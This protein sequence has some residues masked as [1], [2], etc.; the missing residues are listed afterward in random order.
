M[1]QHR[2]P[3]HQ[4]QVEDAMVI[5]WSKDAPSWARRRELCDDILDRLKGAIV[6]GVDEED[7]WFGGVGLD[8]VVG[9]LST[10]PAFQS[11]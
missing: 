10:V 2:A 4:L 3:S 1:N 6:L 11:T 9:R 8:L 7:A 5:G